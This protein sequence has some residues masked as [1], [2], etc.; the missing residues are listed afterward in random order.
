MYLIMGLDSAQ[1]REVYS[2]WEGP[3]G[4]RDGPEP[5]GVG[6]QE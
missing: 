3:E 4:D 5:G 6:A 2:A 1:G